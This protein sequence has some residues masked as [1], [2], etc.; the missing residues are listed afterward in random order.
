MIHQ[1]SVHSLKKLFDMGLTGLAAVVFGC[2][3]LGAAGQQ[4]PPVAAVQELPAPP[5]VRTHSR[6]EE[7]VRKAGKIFK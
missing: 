3:E 7:G 4:K 6:I 2:R 5:D 1:T